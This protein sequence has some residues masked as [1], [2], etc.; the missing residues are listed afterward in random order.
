M[1]LANEVMVAFVIQVKV[2]CE[3]L[4][5]FVSFF[6]HFPLLLAAKTMLP[7]YLYFKLYAHAK[8]IV[9]S[10]SLYHAERIM[11]TKIVK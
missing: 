4:L 7:T 1:K 11:E 9:L 2:L 5:H 6:H 3:C 8:D 10:I